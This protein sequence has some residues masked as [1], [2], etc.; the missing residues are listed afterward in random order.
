[1]KLSN[2]T[3]YNDLRQAQRLSLECVTFVW[4]IAALAYL[5][6]TLV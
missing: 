5:L 4:L 3:P 6:L 1:M 2:L